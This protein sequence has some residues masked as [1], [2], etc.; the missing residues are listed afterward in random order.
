MRV[1]QM[2]VALAMIAVPATSVPAQLPADWKTRLFQAREAA[3]RDFFGN[4]DG[5]A[6]VLPDDFV[7]MSDRYPW[8]NRAAT[9]EESRQTFAGGSRIATLEFPDN[10]VQQYGEVAIIYTTYAFSLRQG[11]KVGPV[12]KGQATELFRWDGKRWLHTGWHLADAGQ[13]Q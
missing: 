8:R 5:L 6:A 4:P 12:T 9:L 10:I 3:W 2:I 11:D 13:R 7:G 1:P